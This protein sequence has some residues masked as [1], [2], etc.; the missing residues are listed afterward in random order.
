[1]DHSRMIPSVILSLLF[2]TIFV[3]RLIVGRVEVGL[4]DFIAAMLLPIM[5]GYISVNANSWLLRGGRL[6]LLL[7]WGGLILTGIGF[8]I[9][10]SLM[11]LDR[12][13]FPTEMWQ[14]V[15]RMMFFY[16]ALY[17]AYTGAVSSRRFYR[18]FICV[19][20]GALL[21][22]VLQTIPCGAGEVLA[23]I[24]ARSDS[25][26][27]K[28]VER[29]F[30]VRRNYGVA[31]F[32]TAWGG[33]AMFSA[34]P[35]LAG[36]ISDNGSKLW[37]KWLL[38]CMALFNVVLSGS[39]VVIAACL[40]VFVCFIFAGLLMKR[41]KGV[42]FLKCLSGIGALVVIGAYYLMD[43]LDFILFRF[44][45]LVSTAGG[46][47]VDQISA[48]M[49]L[50]NGWRA[51]SLGVGNAAQR[52]MA[53]SFGTEAEPVYLLINYGI[54]GVVLRYGLLLVI[55]CYSYRLLRRASESDKIPAV[56]AML[57]IIGYMVFSLGYFFYQELY[58]GV[59]PWLLFG[60]V[61]GL[62]YRASRS[63][64]EARVWR[65]WKLTV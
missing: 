54:L 20:F 38:L 28:L 37:L 19:L 64:Q 59:L 61:V 9:F 7:L 22:G 11:Y 5:V 55:F 14:Y 2:I 36:L 1:M 39:R 40:V 17:F 6:F 44:N 34:T 12:L 32:S 56:A 58:V 26:L 23:G 27:E 18:L 10:D 33:F 49:D 3:P 24:Y 42:F 13:S 43:R 51:W 31:G 16:C 41:K 52:Q 35:A 30:S 4:D 57:S 8:G 46:V 47:R 62:Y 15:K 48:G 45:T 29:S 25:Q 53:A 21:I 63:N 60:W 50:L 65:K